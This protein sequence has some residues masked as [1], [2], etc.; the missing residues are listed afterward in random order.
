MTIE[1]TEK[2]TEDIVVKRYPF[3]SCKDMA[4]GKMIIEDTTKR[5]T[6]FCPIAIVKDSKTP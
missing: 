1:E 5:P 4:V 2:K 3:F 6:T